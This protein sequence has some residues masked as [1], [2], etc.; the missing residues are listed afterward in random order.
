MTAAQT[1]GG[2]TAWDYGVVALYFAAVMLVGWYYSRRQTDLGEYFLGGRTQNWIAV[3]LSVMATLVSTITY[4]TTPGEIIKNGPGVLWSAL[5]IWLAYPI[6]GYLIIPRIMATPIVSGYELLERQFGR[7]IRRAAALLFVLTRLS[8]LGLVVF[9]CSVALSAMTGIPVPVLLVVVGAVTTAYTTMGGFRA[10]V[11]T[12]V[13]QALILF[14]GTLAVVFYVMWHFGS[15]TAW[16]PDLR[17]LDLGWKPTPVFPTSLSQRITVFGIVLHQF[18]WWIAASSSDQLTIQRYLSTRDA[19]SARRSFLTNAVAGLFLGVSLAL[20]GFALLGFF[21]HN[22]QLIPPAE[23]PGGLGLSA[24]VAEEARK[25]GGLEGRLY[26]LT[27]GADKL[28]PW[29]IAHVLPPVVSGLLLAALFSAAMSS[30]SSG[31]NSVT[32]VLMVDFPERFAKVATTEGTVARARSIGIAVGTLAILVAFVQQYIKGNFMEVAQKVNLF[33]IAPV[34]ALFLMA[35]YM[36]RSNA[37]GAWAAVISGFLVGVVVSYYS[38]IV[39]A[40]TGRDA[41]ISFTYILP[42]SLGVSLLAG[43]L[44]SLPYA[45][46]GGSQEARKPAESVSVRTS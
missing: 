45:P 1:H 10:V 36:K 35:F 17:N 9:T 12:D 23:G 40:L 39:K 28:F 30:V 7:G 15:V 4:L 33:F 20:V 32:T 46:G 14:G 22:P 29:F 34:A 27:H 38:E 3:G 31:V 37:A 42:F 16:W 11:V 5:S 25:L 13:M 43:Y 41:Y 8:W 6:I 26:V 21:T 24:A 18:I 2:L 19:A 44:F